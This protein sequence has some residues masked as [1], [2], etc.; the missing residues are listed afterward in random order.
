[1][2]QDLNATVEDFRRRLGDQAEE[3][4]RLE[5]AVEELGEQAEADAD[6]EAPRSLRTARAEL[7]Q[8]QSLLDRT[9]RDYARFRL[10]EGLGADPDH[11]DDECFGVELLALSAGRLTRREPHSPSEGR[12]GFAAFRELMLADL[13]LD[14]LA[15]N[16][17]AE[18]RG[19]S[20]SELHEDA[21]TAAILRHWAARLQADPFVSSLL[22]RAAEAA[23]RFSDRLA[24]FTRKLD[25]LRI[26]YEI[27]QRKVDQLTFA[28][29][30]GRPAIRADNFWENIADQFAD[31]ARGCLAA[32]YSLEQARDEVRDARREL[33]AALREFLALFIPRYVTYVSR[34]SKARRRR[35]RLPRF[36]AGRLC[37]YLL[38]EV[39]MTDFLLPRGG[40]MEVAV[41]RMPR[42]LAPFR[43]M[44]AFRDYK[45][46]LER[47]ALSNAPTVAEGSQ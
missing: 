29:D 47:T 46:S 17:Q 7:G 42:H 21:T 37:A 23:S 18:R 20:E 39:E 12:I 10:R 25:N 5:H 1:M 38:R 16:E 4:E 43:R 35:L 45:K 40:G 3:V 19:I 32:F 14:Q 28:T 24:A 26:N 34:Q 41:P 22:A 11:L 6:G 8:A 30:G 27:K 13:G 2:E 33:N 31:D 15:A 36:R 9:L 44:K